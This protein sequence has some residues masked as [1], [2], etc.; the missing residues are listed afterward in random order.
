MGFT[1]T[2][3]YIGEPDFNIVDINVSEIAVTLQTYLNRGSKLT[4]VSLDDVD[5][6]V[7]RLPSNRES[8]NLVNL[9]EVGMKFFDALVWLSAGRPKK[10]P[11][12]VDPQM[13]GDQI[14][15]LHELSRTV[16]YV[17]FFLLTQARYP[18]HIAE[19]EAPK[20]PNFL[21]VILGMT[22]E[23]HVYVQRICSFAP[24]KFDPGWIKHVSFKN[25]GQEVMSRFGLGVAGYRMFSPFRLFAC[26]E[27]LPSN[28]ANAVQFACSVATSPA[29][30]DIH[31]LTRNVNILKNR[32]NLN[33]NLGN[34]MLDVFTKEQL[35]EMV[36]TKILFK[37][38]E[39]TSLALNYLAW[40]S[41]NDITGES[42]I[43]PSSKKQGTKIAK[44]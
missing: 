41:E 25:F 6:S 21:K 42:Y 43:F 27:G 20:V 30:W 19:K 12:V 9:L 37:M 1:A 10:Y 38:P 24:Q 15:S 17:Y 39:R 40:G 8:P 22:E 31:P 5:T 36:S 34:L 16:F 28:L 7:I 26:K 44:H 2:I 3:D 4:G 11:L 23:Q 29:T 18:V 14:L 32:G 35:E 33:K 13:L